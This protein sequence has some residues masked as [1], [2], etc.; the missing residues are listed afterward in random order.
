MTSNLN[1][2]QSLFREAIESLAA[3]KEENEEVK[4]LRFEGFK[5][6]VRVLKQSEEHDEALKLCTLALDSGIEGRQ[7]RTMLLMKAQSF[8]GKE[9]FAKA[10]EEFK[11]ALDLQK[12]IIMAPD[13]NP[14]EQEQ[15]A[16]IGN[17][18]GI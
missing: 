2:A 15:M 8:M 14:S 6:S 12:S 1:E 18:K 10:T 4:N 11:A 9:E 5:S 13:F 16:E 7:R 3:V 17:L